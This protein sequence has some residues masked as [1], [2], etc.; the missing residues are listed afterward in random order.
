MLNRQFKHGTRGAEPQVSWHKPCTAVVLGMNLLQWLF[1]V[2]WELAKI[3]PIMEE[4]SDKR[5]GQRW[6]EIIKLETE[7]EK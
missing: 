4:E 7:T 1:L 3:A 5:L 2:I 6:G